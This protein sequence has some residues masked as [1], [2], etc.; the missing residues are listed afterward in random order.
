[1][2]VAKGYIMPKDFKSRVCVCVCV[3]VNSK[4]KE[5]LPTLIHELP[6]F[7]KEKLEVVLSWLYKCED[8]LKLKFSLWYVK[9]EQIEMFLHVFLMLQINPYEHNFPPPNKKIFKK[10]NKKSVKSIKKIFFHF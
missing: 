4:S 10:K 8:C 2:A 9:N 3:R 6:K 1:M 7:Y 5:K